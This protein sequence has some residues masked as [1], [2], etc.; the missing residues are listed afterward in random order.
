MAWCLIKHTDTFKE[1][2]V[3][4]DQCTDY[5]FV[6]ARASLPLTHETLRQPFDIG[7]QQNVLPFQ[8]PRMSTSNMADR[9]HERVQEKWH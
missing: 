6:W 2:I 3:I 9:M 1:K 8:F 4:W 7:V 5:E